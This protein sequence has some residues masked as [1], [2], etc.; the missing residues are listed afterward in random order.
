MNAIGHVLQ[1]RTDSMNATGHILQR[2]S[3]TISATGHIAEKVKR[4]LFLFDIA[5]FKRLKRLLLEMEE[6]R[7]KDDED[8]QKGFMA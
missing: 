5:L 3:D 6:R 1:E 8:A 7:K 4:R 2:R